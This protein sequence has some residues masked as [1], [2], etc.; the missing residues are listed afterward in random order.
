LATQVLVAR[1]RSRRIALPRRLL[2]I[3]STV[4]VALGVA[5]PLSAF[6]CGSSGY[7]YAGVFGAQHASGISAELTA[8][9][10]PQVLGGHTAAW[11]GVGGPG[12]G[13]NGSDEWIQIGLSAFPG[14]GVS[15]L[16]YEITRPGATPEYHQLETGILPGTSRRVMVAEVRGTPGAWRVWVD[17]KPVT[18]PI[19][20]PGSHGAW[21]PVATA[22]SWGGGLKPVCNGYSYRFDRVRVVHELGSGWRKLQRGTSFSDPGYRLLFQAPGTFLAGRVAA[23]STQPL[24]QTFGVT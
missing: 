12:M 8:V 18:E 17:G 11:V 19:F 24:R 10:A 21:L 1:R 4:L 3:A 15:N 5:A 22:E 16:Y 9:S 7:T 13:P 6:A 14:T 23:G 20:L 2:V